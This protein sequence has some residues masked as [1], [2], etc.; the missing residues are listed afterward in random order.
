MVPGV[1]AGIVWWRCRFVLLLRYEW[2][3]D[4]K[5]GRMVGIGREIM[6]MGV[7]KG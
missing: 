2:L 7:D 6:M 1:V 5:M 3:Y 4:N